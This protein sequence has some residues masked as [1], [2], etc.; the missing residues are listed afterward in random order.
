MTNTG[1][2]LTGVA[3]GA[4]AIFALVTLVDVDVSGDVEL[5][6][7]EM[8]GGNIELPEIETSGGE[9]PAVDVNTADI[10]VEETEK[11]VEVPTDVNVETEERSVTV[12]TLDF[13]SPEENTA[14]EE[15]DLTQ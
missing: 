9:M 12:P 3:V 2:I 1:K 7:V 14:A 6:A 13:E 11:T 8:V 5:P 15:N 4:I 10:N